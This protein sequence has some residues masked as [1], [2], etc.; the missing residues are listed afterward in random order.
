MSGKSSCMADGRML[1][2]D[3]RWAPG[4][5]PFSITATGT[6]PSF[7]VSCGSFS[8]SCVSRIAQA[9]P[10]GPPPT[11][12]TP[13]SMRSSSASVGGPTNSSGGLTGGGNLAGA[14]PPIAALTALLG[15]H[16]LGQLGHDLVQ[17]AH[18]PEIAELEDRRVR[19]LVDRD[20]VLRRLHSDLV[21]DRARDAGGEIQLRR[22]GLA[23]LADLPRVREPAR[24]HHRARRRDGPA[25]RL[26]E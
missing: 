22:D 8:S 14:T 25:E 13:T 1:A 21:L 18:D 19:V 4:V 17:V 24:V 6:S 7:S 26:R 3:S 23:R 10:A 12:A 9:R 15:L 5:L 11:I 2:P 20:D 16:G